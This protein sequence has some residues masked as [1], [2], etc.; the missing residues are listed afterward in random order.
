MATGPTRTAD[1]RTSA[2][3]RSR[4]VLFAVTA[5]PRSP[6]ILGVAALLAAAALAG[7]APA[8]LTGASGDG[9]AGSVRPAAI[10]NVNLAG[11]M[12]ATADL[13]VGFRPYPLLTGPLDARRGKLLNGEPGQV[14]AVLHGWVRVWNW[15]RAGEQVRELVFDAGTDEHA[16]ASLAGFDSTAS[17]RG[18]GRA[19]HCR[20]SAW[21]QARRTD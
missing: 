2:Q 13:P 14:A 15:A 11:R 8:A 5:V 21:L 18:A 10:G 1:L 20:S 19:A 4:H 12:L 3:C 6:I 9:I 16:R 17:A 7:S